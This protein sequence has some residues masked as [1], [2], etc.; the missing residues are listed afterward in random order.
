MGV[1][2][3]SRCFRDDHT[4]IFVMLP[5]LQNLFLNLLGSAFRSICKPQKKIYLTIYL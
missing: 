1:I 3:E 4:L 2:L 5:P